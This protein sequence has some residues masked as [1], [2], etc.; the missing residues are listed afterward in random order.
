MFQLNLN[1]MHIRLSDIDRQSEL[2]LSRDDY[3]EFTLVCRCRYL[4]VFHSL[5]IL[6]FEN[7]GSVAQPN[8]QFSNQGLNCY[9][10]YKFLFYENIFYHI[11]HVEWS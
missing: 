10:R 2:L 8:Y 9:S 3:S 11:V 5:N 1:V 4:R 6:N 7:W